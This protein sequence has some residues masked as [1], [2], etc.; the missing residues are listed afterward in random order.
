MP[1]A[2][3]SAWMKKTAWLSAPRAPRDG[4]LAPNGTGW[5]VG[6]GS[7]RRRLYPRAAQAFDRSGLLVSLAPAVTFLIGQPTTE[8]LLAVMVAI[9]GTPFALF[10]AWARVASRRERARA[11]P[12]ERPEAVAPGTHV[13]FRATVCPQPTL[14]TAAGTTAAVLVRNQ[15]PGLDETRGIDFWVE[16]PGGQRVKVSARR[17]IFLNPARRGPRQPACGPVWFGS[18][19]RSDGVHSR[20]QP[21]PPTG[22]P[23]WRRL[24]RPHL[25]EVALRP[26]DK[27]DLWG[28][29]EKEPAH[30]AEGGPGRGTPLRP[31]L[32]ARGSIHL[33]VRK[34]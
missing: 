8:V 7:I 25:R 9:A 28:V 13:R 15:I 16:T 14:T 17:A 26:G 30:D 29:L 5:V 32:R 23:L 10:E 19:S 1:A 22:T 12:L 24:F 34:L 31:V 18:A 4:D 20:I 3:V 2:P 33:F 27:V 11:V 21:D 6:L